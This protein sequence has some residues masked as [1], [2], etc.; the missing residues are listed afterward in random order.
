MA[1]DT[2]AKRQSAFIDNWGVIL[3]DGTIDAADRE[4]LI[5][6]YGGIAAAPPGTGFGGQ[7]VLVTTSTGGV[8]AGKSIVGPGAPSIGFRAVKVEVPL[9]E[10]E[11]EREI[12]A[13]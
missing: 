4:T 6:Q 8:N 12:P 3:P 13:W 1:I 9:L 10:R 11:V 7:M 2:A 5:G